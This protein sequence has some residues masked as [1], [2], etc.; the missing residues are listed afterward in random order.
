MGN[1]PPPSPILDSLDEPV[2]RACAV[3]AAMQL[4]IFTPLKDGPLTAETLAGVLGVEVIKLRPLL[5]ALV[6]IGLLIEEAGRLANSAEADYYLV[7]GQPTYR[8]DE[9]KFYQDAWSAIFKTAE[10]IR[11]GIPQ[12]KH[13][14]GAM[15]VETL[16]DFLQGL[17]PGTFKMGLWLAET[18]DFSA[19][20]TILDAG[21]GSGALVIALT[22]ALP[23]LRAVVAELPPVAPVTRRFVT[24]AGA[25][26]RVQVVG[27][28]LVFKTLPRSF[29]AAL[30]KAFIQTMPL[31][32]AGQALG[33]IY[34]MLN[35]GVHFTFWIFPWMI[36]DYHLRRQ[37]YQ[38][39][40]S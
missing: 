26:E 34:Q 13:E 12:A 21:G 9:Y 15:P 7:R 11:T 39:C 27:V 18:Y 16:T 10:T 25:M 40:F 23:D 2:Y 29:D 3:L 19:Y 8:G 32:Q 14:Y 24:Q 22:E 30:L 5:Y 33:N 31:K 37:F 17:Y 20:R 36:H 6:V 38:T 35:P 28:D 4:D 1:V